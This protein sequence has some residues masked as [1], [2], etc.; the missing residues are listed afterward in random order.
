M[1]YKGIKL[2]D[3]SGTPQ[4]IDP[5]REMLVW[6]DD[7]EGHEKPYAPKK[8]TVLAIV[9]SDKLNGRVIGEQYAAFARYGHCAEIPIAYATFRQIARWLADG[10]GEVTESVGCD[11]AYC[12]SSLYY[13]SAKGDVSSMGSAV[14][15]RKWDDTEWHEPTLEYMGLEG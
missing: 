10:N 13:F 7:A 3:I 12:K 2:Q 14:R 11:G 9:N 8:V 15:I 5:P 4:V 6:D 1:E